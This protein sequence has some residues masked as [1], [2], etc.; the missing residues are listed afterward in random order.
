VVR[1]RSSSSI[2]CASSNVN[3]LLPFS[4]R[5][6]SHYLKISECKPVVIHFTTYF[7]NGPQKLSEQCHYQI[8]SAAFN[9]FFATSHLTTKIHG[10]VLICTDQIQSE[11]ILSLHV[12]C[13]QRLSLLLYTKY[14]M[15]YNCVSDNVPW[16]SVQTLIILHLFHQ[17][18]WY[19]GLF[20]NQS[21][22]IYLPL[23]ITHL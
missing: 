15:R 7:H 4:R 5:V 19:F 6:C 16:N 3:L 12:Y 2:K 22:Q 14:D 1:T 8:F 20:L 21:H 18:L 9:S 11:L 10:H 17:D 13:S 23:G